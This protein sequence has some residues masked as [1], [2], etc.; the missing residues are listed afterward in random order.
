[1][2][3]QKR[4]RKG[5]ET[6]VNGYQYKGGEF[7]PSTQLPPTPKTA[8]RKTGTGK[9][10]IA[11]YTWELPPTPDHKSI[12][13]RI[14]GKVTEWKVWNK[15]LQFCEASGVENRLAYVGLTRAQAEDLIARW[16]R[17]ERWY[18]ETELQ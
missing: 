5:G 11:N 10:E 13:V 2:T 6:G 18:T 9:Q 14:A 16:N 12:F 1:M 4:A 17:G 15:E 3:Q 7:L 8:Q